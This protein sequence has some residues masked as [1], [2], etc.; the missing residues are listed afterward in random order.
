MIDLND[1]D[2]NI[3]LEE[4]KLPTKSLTLK[5]EVTDQKE[6][7]MISTNEITPMKSS[8]TAVNSIFDKPKSSIFALFKKYKSG[9]K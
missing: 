3:N 9:D 6:K 7:D 2:L 8:F 4:S 5:Y 1:I